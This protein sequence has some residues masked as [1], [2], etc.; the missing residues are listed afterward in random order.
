MRE[1]KK[2][3]IMIWLFAL[4]LAACSTSTGPEAAEDPAGYVQVFLTNGRTENYQLGGFKFALQD[5]LEITD[6]DCIVTTVTTEE[7]AEVVFYGQ[8]PSLCSGGNRWEF[9]VTTRGS[10]VR[11]HGESFSEYVQVRG[12]DLNTGYEKFINFAAI[13]RIVF[14]R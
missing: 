4:G 9:K 3:L 14:N 2:A 7:M 13:E 11:G 6:A 5:Y 12:L 1:T 10:E 8:S